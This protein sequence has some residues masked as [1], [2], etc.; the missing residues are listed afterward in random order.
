MQIVG[1]P[2]AIIGLSKIRVASVGSAS[3]AKCSRAELPPLSSS[4]SITK[5][6]R[7][8]SS[9]AAARRCTAATSMKRLPLSSLAPRAKR[10]PSRTTGSNGGLVQS[11]SGPGGWTS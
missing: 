5:A 10:L 9:P 2:G 4:P 3:A 7:T 8:G 11:S 1:R 6:A